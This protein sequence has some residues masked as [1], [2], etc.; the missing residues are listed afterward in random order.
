MSTPNNKFPLQEPTGDPK[1]D[2]AEQDII[3]N[4]DESEKIV[5]QDSAV[6]DTAGIEETLTE[7]DP[8]PSLNAEQSITPEA[9]ADNNNAAL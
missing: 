3:T 8:D 7:S 9:E 5:N 6:A 1:V 2:A 4:S